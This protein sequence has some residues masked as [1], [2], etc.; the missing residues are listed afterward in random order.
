MNLHRAQEILAA[1]EKITVE[2]NGVPVWIDSVDSSKAL[3]K[4]HAEENPAD[5]RLVTVQELEE[6]H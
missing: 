1:D 5:S 2:L 6:V 3:A 4:V